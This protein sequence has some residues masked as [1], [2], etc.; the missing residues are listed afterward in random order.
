MSE[1]AP[2]FTTQLGHEHVSLLTHLSCLE[3]EVGPK[4]A[5]CSGILLD[6]LREVRATLQ[7][8]FHFE[9]QGGYMSYI[10]AEDAPHLYR[11]AQELLA[12]H[13]RLRDDLEKLIASAAGVP[14][15]SL[16]TAAVRE[17][18]NHW[19]Q[20]VR[21]HEGRENRLINQACNQDIGADD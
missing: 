12:E 5:D 8:H 1:T 19:V 9:E 17:R 11:A 10:L 7:S 3:E 18:V 13:G 2:S 4:T 20:L 16:V 6:R 14:P 21:G 15:E